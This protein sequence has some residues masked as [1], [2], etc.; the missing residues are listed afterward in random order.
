M[1]KRLSIIAAVLICIF[2]GYFVYRF[3]SFRPDK[4]SAIKYEGKLI[5]D[6]YTDKSRYNPNDTV[7]L[8]IK[9]NKKF[10]KSKTGTLSVYFKNLDSTVE[11]KKVK[12]SLDKDT[13]INIKWRAPNKNF[14]G[15]Q[16]EV[17]AYKGIY[18]YDN[19]N[20][21]V[22]V[23]SSWCKFPRYGY[24]AEYPNQSKSVSEDIINNL[25]KYHIDGL[26]FYDWQYKHNK[27]L[28][29]TVEK[30]EDKWSDIA[31]RDTYGKTVKDYIEL[32]HSKNIMAANYNLMFGAYYN[33]EED[34]VKKEWGLY[35][36]EKHEE[37][38]FHPL[39]Q[40]WASSQLFLFNPAN[41]D[42]QDYILK[43]EKEAMSV[44]KFDVFHVDTLGDRGALFDYNGN[45]VDLSSGYKDFLNTAK[46]KLGKGILFNPVGG[47]GESNVAGNVDLDFLY[48]EVWPNQCASYGNLK[49]A[50]DT[51]RGLSKNKKNVVLAAYMNYN[52]GKSG[53]EFNEPGVRLTDAVIFASGGAHIELGD[54]GMLCNEY[55]PNK[56]LSMTPSLKI[57]IRNYYDF[58]VAYE[59]LLRDGVNDC[60]NAVEMSNGKVS[61]DADSNKIWAFSKE[62]PG[63][64][65]IHLINNLG[66]DSN[67]WVDN[68][69]DVKKPTV[70]NDFELKYYFNGKPKKV[71][72]ASP[73]IRGGHPEALSYKVKNDKKGQYLLIKVPELQY[74]DM[75]C[76]EK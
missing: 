8:Y 12:Y 49:Q 73:D 35:K 52:L 41:K 31:N 7:N 29:G 63:Y 33:Y 1:K 27:P 2:I 32:A 6:V 76:V 70:Q 10:E 26:Q 21:A 74:W 53:S 61:D 65:I 45:P 25:T 23:S 42:W 36:D 5:E 51:S 17:Y 15:Y 11:R 39:P 43:Q 30:P 22:D 58:L 44:Y 68:D 19:K 67:E 66:N 56:N 69:G 34:G 72:I 46:S 62:K 48:K 71:W 59:N 47:Y 16:V 50:I 37:Q 55:F 60:D 40:N 13:S 20:T 54:T 18:V 14:K 64:N 57:A 24:I 9:L 4:V 75:I 28:A 3:L 38:D